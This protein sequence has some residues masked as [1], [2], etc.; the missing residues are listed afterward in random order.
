MGPA[1]SPVII[2]FG[3]EAQKARVAARHPVGRGLLVPGLLGAAAP[4]RPGLLAVQGGERDGDH[5]V[6]NGTKIWTTHA[7]YANRMFCLVR[8]TSG[9][10]PQ[11]GI[12]FLCFD[13]PAPGITVRPIISI[14]ATTSSTRCSSTT[15]ACRPTGSSARRTRAGPSPSTCCSTSAAG[16][17]APT[18]VR[19]PAPAGLPRQMHAFCRLRRRRTRSRRHGVRLAEAEGAIDALRGHRAATRCARRPAASNPA[20]ARRWA[21]CWPETAPAADRARRG[22][23]RPLRRRSTCRWTTACKA[24]CRFPKT[25]CS[26]M[27]AYLNDRA[28]SIYAGSNEVQRNL[29]AAHLAG[30]TGGPSMSTLTELDETLAM[31]RDSLARYLDRQPRLRDP[32]AVPRCARPTMPP[33]AAAAWPSELDLLGAALP[34]SQGGLGGGMAA[35]LAMMEMLGGASRRRAVPVDRW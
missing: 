17:W 11:Q 3:T 22:N 2:A 34:E 20:S 10:K 5:Y 33:A 12:S 19:A 16:A 14:S 7:Q 26:S 27:S 32:R 23:R 4:A 35:H 31:L 9:G 1:W 15:C 29:V 18:C 25:P 8:T 13:I 6:I 30:R 24:S 21:R 28:A